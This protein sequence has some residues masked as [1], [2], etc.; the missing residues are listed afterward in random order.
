MIDTWA[1]RSVIKSEKVSSYVQTNKTTASLPA[2]NDKVITGGRFV[3]VLSVNDKSYTQQQ[4]LMSSAFPWD[5]IL[6]NY[7]DAR[8]ED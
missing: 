4:M 3:R 1:T 8:K 2:A 5:L 7:K 6:E